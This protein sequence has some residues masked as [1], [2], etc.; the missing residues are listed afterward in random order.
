MSVEILFNIEKEGLISQYHC[1]LETS[2]CA[3]EVAMPLILQFSRILL[4]CVFTTACLLKSSTTRPSSSL[5]RP[6]LRMSSG[7]C[8]HGGH[9]GHGG[10][11][12]RDGQLQGHPHL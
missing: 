1:I 9:G 10:H 2:S 4:R 6:L 3:M 7:W 12:G 5:R 8:G 11:D